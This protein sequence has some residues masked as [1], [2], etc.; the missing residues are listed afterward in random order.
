MGSATQNMVSTSGVGVMIA[1]NR[2][3]MS[4]AQRHPA[5]HV[6]ART[7]PIVLSATMITGTRNAMPNASMRRMTNPRYIWALMRFALPS[8]TNSLR[9]ATARGSMTHA[10]ATPARNSGTAAPM[11]PNAYRFSLDVRPGVMN[12]KSWYSHHGL[13]SRT[14]RNRETLTFMSMAV[15]TPSKFRP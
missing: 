6:A 12:A 2:N 13:D 10:S 3:E 11:N 9:S 14:P 8:G 5:S 1:A 7:T 4:T 15:A